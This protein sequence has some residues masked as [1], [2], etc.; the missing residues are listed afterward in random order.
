MSITD[1]KLLIEPLS[2]VDVTLDELLSGVTDKNLHHAV[3]TGPPL[4]KEVR[5]ASP[6]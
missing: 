1:G 4:G 3:D 2:D 5:V 6:G